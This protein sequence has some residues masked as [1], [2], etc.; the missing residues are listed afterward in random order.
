MQKIQISVHVRHNNRE[1]NLAVR[2][3]NPMKIIFIDLCLKY[4][5][6]SVPI[7]LPMKYNCNF[8]SYFSQHFNNGNIFV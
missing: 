3:T 2:K 7:F 4:L 6:V 1:H 8:Q 5:F